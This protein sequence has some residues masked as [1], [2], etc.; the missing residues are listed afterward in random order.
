M[1]GSRDRREASDSALVTSYID[2]GLVTSGLQ[3]RNL[4]PTRSFPVVAAEGYTARGC[5]FADVPKPLYPMETPSISSLQLSTSSKLNSHNSPTAQWHC[6][7]ITWEEEITR[8]RLF[9]GEPLMFSAFDGDCDGIFSQVLGLILSLNCENKCFHRSKTMEFSTR[10]VKSSFMRFNG[11]KDP[12]FRLTWWL[13]A[14]FLLIQANKKMIW[15]QTHAKFQI[16]FFPAF[17][18][19]FYRHCKPHRDKSAIWNLKLGWDEYKSVHVAH[20]YI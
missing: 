6:D 7:E 8:G 2:L 19:L 16:P 9:S 5:W 12:H 14:A 17:L 3:E 13:I 10:A 1:K 11:C 4:T 15:I 18:V 20:T